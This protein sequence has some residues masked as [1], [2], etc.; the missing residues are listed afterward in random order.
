MKSPKIKSYFITSKKNYSPRDDHHTKSRYT[1]T[2]VLLG[3]EL[4]QTLLKQ[5][6]QV[7]KC[8]RVTR[9][10]TLCVVRTNLY[11]VATILLLLLTHRLWNSNELPIY[12]TW[13]SVMCYLSILVNAQPI[14]EH[15]Y[16]VNRN[17][18]GFSNKLIK[19]CKFTVYVLLYLLLCCYCI[20]FGLCTIIEY[21][22]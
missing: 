6:G 18:R 19:I 5:L 17:L 12:G 4:C 7:G 15:S 21:C 2:F 8:Q 14:Y 13:D 9:P 16:C 11:H 22:Y 20:V 3:R 10:Y 1:Q